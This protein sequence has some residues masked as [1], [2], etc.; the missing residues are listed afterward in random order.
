MRVT[1][2]AG[3]DHVEFTDHHHHRA[4]TDLAPRT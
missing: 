3:V 4:P 2:R 1:E